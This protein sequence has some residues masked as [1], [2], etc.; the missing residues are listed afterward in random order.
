[1][2]KNSPSPD[3]EINLSGKSSNDEEPMQPGINLPYGG[4]AQ[5]FGDIFSQYG[6]HNY[7]FPPTYNPVHA[8]S[9]TDA[10]GSA[11]FPGYSSSVYE[12]IHSSDQFAPKDETEK[13]K[14]EEKIRNFY[15]DELKNSS[16]AAKDDRKRLEKY[17]K[18]VFG[19]SIGMTFLGVIF[20][21][22]Q[23]YYAIRLGDFSSLS[24]S[25]EIHNT[26]S[27]II[28]TS[29][30][31]A[32]VLTLSLVFFFLFLNYVYKPNK[33]DTT[34]FPHIKGARDLVE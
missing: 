21:I 11:I 14:Y 8:Y 22:V 4:R 27:L 19:I 3:D 30:I 2:V 29:V 15:L 5:D 28:T 13:E 23:F 33:K 34:L 20:S 9:S 31:G 32:F 1:M 12:K 25:L 18:W 10:S 16:E 17:G 24:T 6:R 26:E 7:G